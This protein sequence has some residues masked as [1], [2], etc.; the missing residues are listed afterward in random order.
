V[1]KTLSEAPESYAHCFELLKE[2][3]V[4]ESRLAEGMSDFT[5]FRNVLVHLYWKVDN[6][7]V[8]NILKHDLYRI[9][10]FL[11]AVSMFVQR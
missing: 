3:G 9:E 1:A 11:G 4:I 5:K 7:R 10:E 6:K 2:K 8:I